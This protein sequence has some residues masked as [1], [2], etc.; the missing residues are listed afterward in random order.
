MMIPGSRGCT[1]AIAAVSQCLVEWM[2]RRIDAGDPPDVP[3]PWIVR[4]N[5]WLAARYGV[6]AEIIVDDHGS[7]VPARHAIASL[8]DDLAPVAHSLRCSDELAR[9]LDILDV[10]PSYLRQRRVVAGGGT[11]IDVVDSLVEELA[12]DRPAS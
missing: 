12:T 10:G 3:L 2:D 7:L 1:C 8:V 9:V 4:Q 11:L 5:K 6:D